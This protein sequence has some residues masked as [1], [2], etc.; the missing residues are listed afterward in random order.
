LLK[1]STRLLAFRSSLLLAAVL[2]AAVSVRPAPDVPLLP[3][4]L[5]VVAIA[6]SDVLSVALPQGGRVTAG[7]STT[8]A[9]AL[10]FPH[11]AA[12][13]AA[14]VGGVAGLF[15]RREAA[16]RQRP[17]VDLAARIL[18]LELS[19]PILGMGRSTG[20]SLGHVELVSAKGL[21]TLLF[22]L[23]F[24]A[25]HLL[26]TEADL[27]LSTRASLRFV[28]LGFTSLVGPVYAALGTLGLL[29]A[30]VYPSIGPWSLLLVSGLLLVCRYSF[31]LYTSL[32]TTYRE[33][34]GALAEA[35]EAQDHLTRGHAE[36][37]SE[38]AVQ[39]GR[40]L[41]MSG[42]RLETLSYAALLHDIGRLA[43]PEDSLDALMDSIPAQ[44]ETHV[45]FHAVRGAEILGQVDYLK[46]TASLVAHHHDPWTGPQ[47]STP[48][49]SSVIRVASTFDHLTYP[50]AGAGGLTG[51][52]ATR[53]MKQ[54][55]SARHD[56]GV[57]R[58]LEVLVAKGWLT[59][60]PALGRNLAADVE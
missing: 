44:G 11:E 20:L 19:L 32:R 50:D 4:L 13:L 59:E 26:I 46:G 43:T 1:R 27:S 10:L 42:R 54:D 34:I 48:L 5:F 47:G 37:T 40:Q 24:C 35:I 49:G 38:L 7:V 58:A 39:L 36:R 53:E 31:N 45:R 29:I 60:S 51:A 52:E 14:V 56:P 28:V 30:V 21:W 12:V 23:V 41:G 8:V 57:M 16:R 9:V 33:T 6:G 55:D 15:L 18:A 2:G 25:I 3:F 22:V 17:A